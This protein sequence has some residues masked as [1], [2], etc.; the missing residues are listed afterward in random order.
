[1][2]AVERQFS[3]FGLATKAIGYNKEKAI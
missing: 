2:I 3:K 1:V